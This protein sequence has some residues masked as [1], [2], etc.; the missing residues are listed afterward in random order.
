MPSAGF[1][2]PSN[3]NAFVWTGL[4]GS[5]IPGVYFGFYLPHGDGIGDRVLE[6]LPKLPPSTD[7]A[8]PKALLMLGRRMF[9]SRKRW[10][11]RTR[12]RKFSARKSGSVFTPIC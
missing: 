5:S 7:C 6:M 11:R 4:D 3:V 10:M 9:R 12:Q 1:P 8:C 2:N